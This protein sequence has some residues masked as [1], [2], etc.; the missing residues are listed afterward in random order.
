[1]DHSER[2]TSAESE[3]TQSGGDNSEAEC[4]NATSQRKMAAKLMVDF[5]DGSLVG[6]MSLL[7]QE[8]IRIRIEDNLMRQLEAD[9]V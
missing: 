2:L 7:D 6:A 9:Q 3:E 1:M 8:N 4:S 5:Q